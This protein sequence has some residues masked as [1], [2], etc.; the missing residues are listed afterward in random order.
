LPLSGSLQAILDANEAQH[1][2]DAKKKGILPTLKE[3]GTAEAIIWFN[4]NPSSKNI[5]N[6]SGAALEAQV[7]TLVEALY[8]GIP[9][10]TLTDLKKLWTAQLMA[11]RASV[12]GELED[13]GGPGPAPG[14]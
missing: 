7:D 3:E 14:A 6:L 10:A 11:I 13:L 2:A 9:A 8:R 1:F 12:R 4:A 5:F